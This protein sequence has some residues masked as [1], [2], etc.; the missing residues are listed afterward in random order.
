MN[1]Q[2]RVSNSAR[3]ASVTSPS[4]ASMACSDSPLPLSSS[5]AF[6]FQTA[7]NRCA[8][9]NG[10]RYQR[11][12]VAD[13]CRFAPTGDPVHLRV[14]AAVVAMLRELLQLAARFE[15]LE[16]GFAN[17]AMCFGRL[18]APRVV[19]GPEQSDAEADQCHGVASHSFAQ[20]MLAHRGIFGGRQRHGGLTLARSDR[21]RPARPQ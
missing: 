7:N 11:R 3:A 19:A 18:V 2:R 5:P 9:L 4:A 10:G 6:S 17:V 12:H 20:R 1:G 21:I 14:I 16:R 8:G 15:Q 13:Q